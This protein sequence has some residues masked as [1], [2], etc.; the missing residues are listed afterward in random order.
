M[1]R[2]QTQSGAMD[3][4]PSEATAETSVLRKR[5]RVAFLVLIGLYAVA[6]LRNAEYWDPLDDLDL[7]VHEAG[8]LVFSAFGETLTI[9]GGSAFQVL[10]PLAFVAYFPAAV[11]TGH[12][13][14]SG[15]PYWLAAASPLVGLLAYLGA[16]LLWRWSLGHYTGVNG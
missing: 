4:V 2:Q 5:L 12:G 16:R 13:G 8:H 9:L 15:V 1:Q 3:A 6:R 7:A 11:L 10:V 14:D